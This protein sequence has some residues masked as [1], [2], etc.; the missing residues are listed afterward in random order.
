MAHDDAENADPG[1]SAEDGP[2][3]IEPRPMVIR[4]LAALAIVAI[5]VL[6]MWATVR[7][8]HNMNHKVR[9]DLNSTTSV[10]PVKPTLG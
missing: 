9:N 3:P 7:A 4:V 10:P 2:P 5:V 8:G 6:L 1:T